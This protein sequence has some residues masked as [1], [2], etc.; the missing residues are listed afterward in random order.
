MRSGFKRFLFV[1]F[2]VA[3][4]GVTGPALGQAWQ[5]HR[6]A[7]FRAFH[8]GDYGEAVEQFEAALF[9][10]NEAREASQNL[11][12]L[13]EH[14]ATAYLADGQYYRAQET[15]DLWDIILAENEGEAWAQ[16][17]QAIRDRLAA[18]TAQ[19]ISQAPQATG[20]DPGLSEAAP[21]EQP[22]EPS[23]PPEASALGAAPEAAQGTTELAAVPPDPAEAAASP[24]A[25]AGSHAIHL[26]S[27]RTKVSAKVL[28]D[29]LKELHPDLLEGK[30]LDVR[31]IDLGD[32][33]IFFRVVAQPFESQASA[34]AACAAFQ[35]EDQYCLVLS[36]N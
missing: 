3:F 9:F 16:D 10:A 14:L 13:L 25:P 34:E 30:R 36:N 5:E 33:G 7:G 18:F 11:G 24:A 28:W 27:A 32:R 23:A 2:L 4:W 31:E 19:A 6:D 15:V 22:A 20:P 17:H 29:N 12:I 21:A 26:A 1:A 8:G 35:G